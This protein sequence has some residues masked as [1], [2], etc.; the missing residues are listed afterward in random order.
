MVERGELSVRDD[1]EQQ[2]KLAR[3]HMRVYEFDLAL[4]ILNPQIEET[5]KQ[6]R[7]DVYFKV[8]P[9][10]LRI[11]S[12][13]N[14]FDEI[15]ALKESLADL[16]I[17][18]GIELTG[19]LFYALGIC[20]AYRNRIDEAE[21]YVDRALKALPKED[22]RDRGLAL[23]LLAMVYLHQNKF[24]KALE[25]LEKVDK[26]CDEISDGVDLRISA[27]ITRALI[28]RNQKSFLKALEALE[29]AERLFAIEPC[30]YTHLNILYAKGSIYLEMGEYTEARFYLS[31][32]QS[33]V[34]HKRLPHWA[35][36]IEKKMGELNEVAGT[37]YDLVIDQVE[38]P[39]IL[40]KRLGKIDFRSQFILF[41]LLNFLARSPG[42]V[43]SKSNIVETIWHEKYEPQRHDNKLYVTIK[44]LRRMIEPELRRPSYILR[45]KGG[46]CLSGSKKVVFRQS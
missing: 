32:V 3:L 24:D 13:M 19:T 17:R 26:I 14:Q 40:E 39:A 31:A 6:K 11:Y 46:Y 44:R 45:K 12:E 18:E 27:R 9:L 35:E 23:N 33:M 28:Y 2:L 36:Q 25:L 20:S 10:L 34:N 8:I 37:D 29:D 22:H 41:E 21:A 7:W 43:Y 38:G 30:L 1:F 5:L 16:V 15:T 4:E 42:K